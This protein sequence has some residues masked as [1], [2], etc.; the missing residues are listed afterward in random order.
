MRTFNV[1]TREEVSTESQ[2]IFDSLKKQIGMV[3]NIYATIGYSSNALASYLT[4]QGAQAK[5]TFSAKEREAVFLAVS[6]ANGCAYCQA[7]H[8]TLGKMNGFTEEQTISLRKG[9]SENPRLNA[10]VALTKDITENRGRAS[11]AKVE[12]FFA[13]GFDNTA[14]VDLITLIAD[15]TLANYLHNLTQV[16]ID[17][18]VAKPVEEEAYA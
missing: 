16:E 12:E 10:I 6:Q 13:Q 5:G 17:F 4:F 14:L 7:A 8:T 2:A 3:P 15:K 11:E 9:E 18:P 1:P